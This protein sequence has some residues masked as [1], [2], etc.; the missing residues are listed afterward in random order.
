MTRFVT[1]LFFLVLIIPFDYALAQGPDII[2]KTTAEEIRSEQRIFDIYTKRYQPDSVSVQYIA[3]I[4]DSVLILVMFGTW[5]HDS[6]RHLPEFLK[7]MEL[8]DNPNIGVEFYGMDRQ[9]KDPEGV[10]ERLGL[11]HTPTFIIYRAGHEIGRIVEEPTLTFE[12]ELV[13]IF[14]TGSGSAQ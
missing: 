9:K 1:P 13:Q 5:C 6:K 8:A 12:K 7:I 3:E 11:K 4:Q 10:S 2:G 14:K